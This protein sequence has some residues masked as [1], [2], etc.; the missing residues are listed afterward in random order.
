MKGER[1]SVIVGLG[2]TLLTALTGYLSIDEGDSSEDGAESSA[3][4]ETTSPDPIIVGR[5]APEPSL[6]WVDDEPVADGRH[7]FSA[8][9]YNAGAPGIVGVTLLWL[10]E[11][12]AESNGKPATRRERFFEA[13]ERGELSVTASAP[14]EYGAYDLRLWVAELV[15][16]IEND[17]AGGR[18]E[19]TVLEDERT[20]DEAEVAIDAGETV[21][22]S[23]TG[24]YTEADPAT[25]DLEARPVS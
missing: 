17:G 1:R 21:S 24:D 22:L 7:E 18:I 16:E 14:E 12:E 6:V 4:G 23:F 19:V 5:T 11:P 8:E 15:V 2:T 3:D 13:N 25:L 20:V 9:I 10:D